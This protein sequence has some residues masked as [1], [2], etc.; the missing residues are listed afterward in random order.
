MFQFN[1]KWSKSIKTG[2]N[3]SKTIK[4]INFLNGFH[5]FQW[6]L[7]IFDLSIDILNWKWIE[8]YQNWIKIYW[9][10]LKSDEFN[11]KCIKIRFWHLSSIGIWFSRQILNRT[12]FDVQFHGPIWF[13]NHN[14]LSLI[15]SN[16]ILI[17]Y[18]FDIFNVKMC[19]S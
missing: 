14:L 13:D 16:M 6:F 18:D 3:P 19:V 2:C 9:M 12:D 17:S 5:Y 4:S 11:Q 7:T 15:D 8:M 10:Y 1:W